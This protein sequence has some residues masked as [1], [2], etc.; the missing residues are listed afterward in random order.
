M[1]LGPTNISTQPHPTSASASPHPS[2]QYG[3]P[4]LRHAGSVPDDMQQP[5]PASNRSLQQPTIEAGGQAGSSSD[6]APAPGVSAAQLEDRLRGLNV[7]DFP[8]NPGHRISEYE[9]ALTP[10]TP[11]QALGFKVVRRAGSQT[12]GAQLTDFPN[13]MYKSSSNCIHVLLQLVY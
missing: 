8:K 7:A 13:G 9:N 10:A 4:Q 5:R 2:Y 1:Q 11:R 3:L 6:D 12:D